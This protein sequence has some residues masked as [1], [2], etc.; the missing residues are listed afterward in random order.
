MPGCA[1]EVFERRN[2]VADAPCGKSSCCTFSIDAPR[3]A[4]V[5]SLSQFGCEP[6]EDVGRADEVA[7]IGQTLGDGADVRADPEDLL[8]QEDRRLRRL[9]GSP[10]VQVHRSIG[11]ARHLIGSSDVMAAMVSH[12]RVLR[13][14]AWLPA[15]A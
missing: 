14:V 8:D 9:V 13:A 4:S 3:P 12:G 7:G 1:G 2:A 6:P 11:A 10:D 5:W 15:C